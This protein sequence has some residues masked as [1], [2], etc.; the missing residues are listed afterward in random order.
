MSTTSPYVKQLQTT[1]ARV[2]EALGHTDWRLVYQSR[3]GPPSQPWLGPDILDHIRGLHELGRDNLVVCPIGFISDHME[4]IY[5][6]D[7][8]AAAL[9]E[10]LGVRM[11][12]AATASTHP[13][14][15]RM[16]RDLM[17]HL[18]Q[19]PADCCPAPQGPPVSVS[20]RPPAASGPA[21]S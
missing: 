2:A 6:L 14:F 16:I 10:E 20:G 13:E 3:S 1:C 9:C 21:G 7:T 19:C 8:E 12:R 18:R 17:L 4:V 11:V 15:I 5:D